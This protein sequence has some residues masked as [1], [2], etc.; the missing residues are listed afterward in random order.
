MKKVIRLTESDLE[1]IIRRVI[2]ESD[3]VDKGRLMKLAERLISKLP[4]K[5]RSIGDA[6]HNAISAKNPKLFLNKVSELSPGKGEEIGKKVSKLFKGGKL[7]VAKVENEANSISEQLSILAILQISLVLFGIILAI[8][9]MGV[10]WTDDLSI[11][12]GPNMMR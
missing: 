8:L 12:Q 6:F 9:G 4:P 7:D 5:F 2:E 1:K 3:D 10:I 11:G